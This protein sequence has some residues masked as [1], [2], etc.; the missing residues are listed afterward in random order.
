[1]SDDDKEPNQNLQSLDHELGYAPH[2]MPDEKGDGHGSDLLDLEKD[3][4]EDNHKADM[5]ADDTTN[6]FNNHL[7]HQEREAHGHANKRTT[8]SKRGSDEKHFDENENAKRLKSGNWA[9]SSVSRSPDGPRMLGRTVGDLPDYDYENVNNREI[10]GNSTSDSPRFDPRSIDLNAQAKPPADMDNTVRLSERGPQGNGAFFMQKDNRVNKE[11]RDEDGHPKDRRPPKNSRGKHLGSHQKKHGALIGKNKESELLSTSQI[12][13][14]PIDLKRSTVINGRGPA[15]HR[16]LSDLEMGE[17]RENWHEEKRFGRNNSFKQSENK[18]SSDY[19]NLDESKGKPN[20][21]LNLHKKVVSED[22]V[23]DFTRFNG[24]QSLSRADHLKSGSQSNKGKHN[25]AGASQG[26]GIGSEGYNEYVQE[27]H[28]KYDCYNTL[29]K[30]LE[31]YRSEFQTFGRDL[32]LAKGKDIERYNKILEQL[33]E[34]YRQCGAKHKR[35]K[36]IFVV[37][38]HELQHLKEMIRDFVEKQTKG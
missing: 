37:L 34:S 28:E 29:N 4:F 1:M 16:E 25:E 33:M 13:D 22:H 7:H 23:D 10:L 21:V 30:I 14:S 2:N 3:L 11:T 15:L 24:K 26:I 32:E 19:W 17:L 38:H 5:H 6:L 35:L 18:S 9:R 36:K 20:D 8:T 31:S 27:Y 12:K